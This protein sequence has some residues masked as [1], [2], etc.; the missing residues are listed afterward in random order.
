MIVVARENNYY[1]YNIKSI[2]RTPDLMKEN[3]YLQGICSQNK[4]ALI[5]LY[6]ITITNISERSPADK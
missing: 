1:F 6:A 5:L 4:K 3:Q 2:F